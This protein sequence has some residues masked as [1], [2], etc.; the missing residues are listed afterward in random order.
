MA[1][2]IGTKRFSFVGVTTG[3]SAIMRVFPAWAEHLGL[4]DVVMSGHDFPLHAPA[5]DYRDLVL[6]L[7]DD[8]HDLGG[9]VV[10]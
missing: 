5:A 6:Q 9:D 10:Q 2:A 8:P 3:K 1:V 4:G 7:K